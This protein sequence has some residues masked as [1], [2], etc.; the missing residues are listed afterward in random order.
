[1]ARGLD[2]IWI[3]FGLWIAATVLVTVIAVVLVLMVAY[4]MLKG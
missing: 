3:R 1:M 4:F 2:R